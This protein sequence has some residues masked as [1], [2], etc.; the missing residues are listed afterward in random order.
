VDDLT[1]RRTY[2]GYFLVQAIAGAGFWVLLWTRPGVRGGFEMLEAER[3]VTSSFLMADLVLGVAGSVVVAVAVLGRRRWSGAL[4]LF[5]AGGIVYATLY[6]LFWVAATGEGPMML[7]IM[8]P[9][10]LMSTYVAV[11]IHRSID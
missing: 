5:V 10:A 4:A 8:A 3:A 7:G 2:A 11:Q 9:T 1:A 6:I